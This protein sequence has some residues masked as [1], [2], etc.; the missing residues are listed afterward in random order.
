MELDVIS[1]GHLNGHSHEEAKLHMYGTDSI[2]PFFVV[3]EHPGLF[4][5]PIAKP[6]TLC[7]QLFTLQR[8]D[9]GRFSYQRTGHAFLSSPMRRIDLLADDGT[10]IIGGVTLNIH[11]PAMLAPLRTLLPMMGTSVCGQWANEYHACHPELEQIH[12]DKLQNLIQ[13]SLPGFCFSL[14]QPLEPEDEILFER[15]ARVCMKR[16]G[17]ASLDSEDDTAAIIMA[18]TLQCIVAFS[19]YTQ[20]IEFVGKKRVAVDRFSADMR[21]CGDGDCEDYAHEIMVLWKALRR[22]KCKTP[23][24]QRL[25][26]A[27]R[28]YVCLEILGAINLPYDPRLEV[29]STGTMYAHAFNVMFPVSTLSKYLADSLQLDNLCAP[30]TCTQIFTLDGTRNNDPCYISP[31]YPHS[32]SMQW[33]RVRGIEAIEPKHYLYLCSAYCV[34][35]VV[36]Q[37]ST[38]TVPEIF[39]VN[40]KHERGVTYDA[41]HSN[42][43]MIIKPTVSLDIFNQF[44]PQV[45]QQLKL[46]H[47]IPKYEVGIVAPTLQLTEMIPESLAKGELFIN[48]ND[49]RDKRFLDDIRRKLADKGLRWV[50]TLE[51]ISQP[52]AWGLRISYV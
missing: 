33:N 40:A 49:V 22:I 43:Q 52:Y 26:Q 20:D 41:V 30:N 47:P 14:I 32:C 48:A 4:T 6:C 44:M 13:P 16:R 38:T 34:D 21:I 5:V 51:F 23:L 7:F 50:E 45:S 46:F 25:Q 10:T 35:G 9:E 17:L 3:A 1:F 18:E 42:Q 24:V 2:A 12:L 15:A 19:S 27:A 36:Y 37:G 8:T 29:Y 31:S 39:F 28:Q 11:T